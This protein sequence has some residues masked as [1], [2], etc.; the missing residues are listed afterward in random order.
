MYSYGLLGV[1]LASITAA[2]LTYSRGALVGLATIG[3]FYFLTARHKLAVALSGLMLVSIGF[4]VLPSRWFDRMHS[5]TS[6]QEDGSANQRIDSWILSYRLARAYVLGGGF[7]CFTPEQ[8]WKFAPR[9][10]INVNGSEAHTAHSIYFEVM[11]EHGFIGFL[12][13]L[14]CLLSLL[15]SLRQLDRLGHFLPGA[16]WIIIYSRAFAISLLGFMACGAFLSRA[17]F[18]LFWSIYAAAVCFHCIVFSGNWIETPRK[19]MLVSN[20]CKP[21]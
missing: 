10:E 14:L 4:G 5:I 7:E 11:A 18:D 12:I 3:F 8:Y 9:P 20:T 1:G 15:L 13:Y 17:F 6:F 21:S 19:V 16:E 2:I